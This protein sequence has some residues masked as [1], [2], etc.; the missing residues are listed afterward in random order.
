MARINWHSRA[1]RSCAALIVT[2]VLIS[3]GATAGAETGSAGELSRMHRVLDGFEDCRALA[4]RGLKQAQDLKCVYL[5]GRGF[6][7][8]MPESIPEDM[9]I[10]GLWLFDHLEAMD[11]TAISMVSYAAA[12]EHPNLAQEVN[13][14]ASFVPEVANR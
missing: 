6:G 7:L 14:F 8:D 12:A 2:V 10:E 1:L 4:M 13:A 11:V 3:I 9:L 5:Y